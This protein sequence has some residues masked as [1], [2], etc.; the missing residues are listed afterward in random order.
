MVLQPALV[1]SPVEH[2][3]HHH[4][5]PESAPGQIQTRPALDI[6]L[7]NDGTGSLSLY[8]TLQAYMYQKIQVNQSVHTYG[9][10]IEKN[11]THISLQHCKH[12]FHMIK[13]QVGFFLDCILCSELEM[14]LYQGEIAFF[15]NRH[16]GF[17]FSI[18]TLHTQYTHTLSSSRLLVFHFYFPIYI[19]PDRSCFS[20]SMCGVCYI[21]VG[22]EKKYSYGP[23]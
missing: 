14:N 9:V 4:H 21:R 20:S 19:F 13:V 3:N 7:T 23:L 1:V 22:F 8:L 6:A 18:Q 12:N 10:L 16:I 2:L 15:Q 5:Q 17:F 11:C